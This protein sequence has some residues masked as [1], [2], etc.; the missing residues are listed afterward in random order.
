[1]SSFHIQSVFSPAKELGEYNFAKQVNYGGRSFQ[2]L[3]DFP[4]QT[5]SL[6]T[7][8][9]CSAAAFLSLFSLSSP[10]LLMGKEGVIRIRKQLRLSWRQDVRRAVHAPAHITE[11]VVQLFRRKSEFTFLA[12]I[13][14]KS[15]TSGVIFSI[16]ESEHRLLEKRNPVPNSVFSRNV[17]P[18]GI[19]SYG[20]GDLRRHT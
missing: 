20:N 19:Q 16:H 3:F 5:A 1:M 8:P 11:K 2:S 13:Q 10:L 6:S 7:K 12:S 9:P 14:Q 18:V 17:F 15:S 4:A